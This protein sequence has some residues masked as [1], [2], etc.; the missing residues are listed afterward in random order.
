MTE[1]KH[2]KHEEQEVNETQAE[3]VE[4]PENGEQTNVGDGSVDEASRRG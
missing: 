3:A 4:L 1:K 2:H